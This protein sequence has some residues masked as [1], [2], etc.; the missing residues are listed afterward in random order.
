MRGAE[1]PCFGSQSEQQNGQ[2]WLDVSPQFG[3]TPK[4]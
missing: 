4:P 2:L 1:Q 3:F